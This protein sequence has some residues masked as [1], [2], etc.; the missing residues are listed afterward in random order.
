MLVSRIGKLYTPKQNITMKQLQ[1][2][3]EN[4]QNKTKKKEF[5]NVQRHQINI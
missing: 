2:K 3:S 1:E 4:K 5:K